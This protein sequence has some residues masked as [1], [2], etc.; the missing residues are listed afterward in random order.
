MIDVEKSEVM[1]RVHDEHI[2]FHIF[3]GIQ[4]TSENNQ[5]MRIKTQPSLQANKMVVPYIDDTTIKEEHKPPQKSSKTPPMI[6]QSKKPKEIH[7]S[8]TKGWKY[9]KIHTEGFTHGQK[10]LEIQPP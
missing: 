10:V 4:T 8:K 7:E 2:T 5:R 3:K 9:K 6:K 1:L